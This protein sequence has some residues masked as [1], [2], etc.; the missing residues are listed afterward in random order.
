MISGE[1][2]FEYLLQL[3]GADYLRD[4]C[5]V[6]HGLPFEW[7]IE[8]DGNLESDGKALRG[9]YKYETGHVYDG[10]DPIY[11]TMLEVLVVLARR[12]DATIGGRDDTPAS[13]FKVL[14]RNLDINYNTDSETIS[15][16]V[17]DVVERN[18]D[19]FGRQ[20]I[21]PNRRGLI[22]PSETSLLDQLS[23]WCNQEKYII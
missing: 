19:R 21:F 8:L 10:D 23:M 14:M 6:L 20:G 17:R 18:Y 4:Q 2:Y 5:E 7:W 15:A 3:V 13:A 1:G 22:D 11:A 12:M 16:K 9:Y